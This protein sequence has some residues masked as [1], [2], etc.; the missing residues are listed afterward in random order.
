M[1]QVR[2]VSLGRMNGTMSKAGRE[3]GHSGVGPGTVS[4]VY[5]FPE[6][7]HLCTV[8]AIK[9]GNHEGVD[10]LSVVDLE[11]D[12]NFLNRFGIPK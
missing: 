4:A 2:P 6:W 11:Q 9:E 12:S 5:H 1:I 8:A 3:F 10:Q 7:Q